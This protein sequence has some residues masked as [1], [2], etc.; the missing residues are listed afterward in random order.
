MQ[1]FTRTLLVYPCVP[2]TSIRMFP[3][4]QRSM[5]PLYTQEPLPADHHGQRVSTPKDETEES[6]AAELIDRW[7]LD[8]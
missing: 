4:L 6:F 8:R 7:Q 5:D 2:G 1:H 3:G